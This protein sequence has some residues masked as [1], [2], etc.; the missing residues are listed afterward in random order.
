MRLVLAAILFIAAF[1]LFA[2]TLQDDLGRSVHLTRTAHRLIL[3]SPDLVETA[4]SIGAEHQIVG[5]VL[6]ADYPRAALTLP[7]MGSLSSLDVERIVQAEPDLII[8]WGPAFLRSLQALIKAGVPVYVYDPKHISDIPRMMRHLGQFSG[9][10]AEA[11]KAAQHFEEIVR[12]AQVIAPVK[13]RVFFEL[14]ARPL[15]TVN[16]SDWMSEVISICGGENIF[17]N[18][19]MRAPTVDL[20][21][22]IAKQPD[23]IISMDREGKRAFEFAQNN[24][25]AKYTYIQP[26]LIARPGPRLTQGITAV[27]HAL[28]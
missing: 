21:A 25:H 2:L 27:C 6:G 20:E 7:L 1:P 24:F 26:D 10:V 3:L 9:H 22:V 18:L 17:A 8:I 28:K 5:V 16:G 12:A 14:N 11:E 13:K 23:I 15:M 4:Y 19:T